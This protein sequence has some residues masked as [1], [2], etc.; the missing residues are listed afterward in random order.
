MNDKIKHDATIE[1]PI[2]QAWHEI[3]KTSEGRILI[4]GIIIAITGIVVM[5]AV[6]FW[7]PEISH[8]MGTMTF[9]NIVFGRAV[10]MSLGYAA[11][12]GHELV[13]P[14]NMWVETVLVLLFYPVF[15]FSMHKLVVFKGLKRFLQ[16]TRAAAERHYDKVHKYGIIG[17]F[18][19]VWFPFWMTRPVVGSA[20]GYL[21]GFS[22]RLTLSI[23]LI[24][25]Y[26][27]MAGWAYVMFDLHS[28][29]ADIGPWAPVLII[30]ML[31][32]LVLV[33]HWVNRH[34][35]NQQ[36]GH[37]KTGKQEATQPSRK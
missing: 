16:R 27:A 13:V 19:F 5:G 36:P 35:K 33:G 20:I 4:L 23:V 14:V 32:L 18:V 37:D 17:L 9:F 2:R 12:Y 29:A 26:V 25:T 28:R 15:V 6:A 1:I 34:G 11:G 22:A 24:G 10:S 7:S 30:V 8:M 31:V 21:L 3:V